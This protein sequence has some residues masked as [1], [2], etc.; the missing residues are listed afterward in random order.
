MRVAFPRSVLA[1]QEFAADLDHWH[2][3]VFDDVGGRIG[4]VP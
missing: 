3:V 1:Q 2:T 4:L